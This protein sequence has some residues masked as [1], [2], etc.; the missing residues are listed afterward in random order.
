MT[1]LRSPLFVL[2]FAWVACGGD[3]TG[4]G[5]GGTGDGSTDASADADL[6]AAL[7]PGPYARTASGV[8]MGTEDGD[9]LY[10]YKG[11]PYAA[12]PTGDRRFRPPVPAEPFADTFAATDFSAMCPQFDDSTPPMLVGDEDCLT[13]NVWAFADSATPRPVMVFIHG[14]AFIQGSS[15]LPVY[16][17]A[18][19]A[20]EGGTVVVTLNYRLG[21]LG[22]LATDALVAESDD[23]SAGNYGIQ[24]QI[25]A[26]TWVRDNIAAFGGD[27]AQVTIFGESAG[28]VSVC[29]HLGS[30]LS[31]GLFQSAIIESGAGCYGLPHLDAATAL[32]PSAIDQGDQLIANLGCDTEPDPLACARAASASDVVTATAGLSAS[33]LGLPNIGPNI[34]GAVITDDTHALFSRGEGND[35]PIIIGSNADEADSFTVAISI[36]DAATYEAVVRA[37]LP[38]VADDVLALYPASDFATPKAAFNALFSDIGFICPAMSFAAAS[39]DGEPTYAYHFTKTLEGVA[40]AFGSVHGLE[41][42]YVFDTL[43]TLPRYTPVAADRRVVDTME[44]AWTSFAASGAPMSDPA[45]PAYDPSAPRVFVIDDP[46]TVT[47]TIREG[48]C[49]E[50]MTLGL[51]Q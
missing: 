4:P 36:P 51:V 32:S 29:Q 27:P 48:R 19:L 9:D 24:D 21:G 31:A 16:D 20:R 22:F 13:L 43:D 33:G 10:I 38:L 39:S 45:W 3:D 15:R 49:A 46:S 42:V 50:L 47:D 18:A 6:D 8:V 28:G 26:L 17:G 2:V 23:G 14:G 7:P 34:D 5:D 1:A 30:P 40:A 12:P 11:I 37:R 25:L 44:T 41:L 35:V